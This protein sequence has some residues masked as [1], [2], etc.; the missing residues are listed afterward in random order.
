MHPSRHHPKT[1]I[2][3]ENAEVYYFQNILSP[4]KASAFLKFLLETVPWK[5]DEFIMFGKRIVTKRKFAWY[6]RPDITYT[7]SNSTRYP[8]PWTEELFQLKRIV[9]NTTEREYN[10]CLLN[11]Y[12][13]GEEG[14]GWHRDNEKDLE[15]EGSIASLSLG[16]TR[17]FSFQSIESKE[18]VTIELQSGSLL[19]ME[20]PTQKYW[21]HA[22]L[23]DKKVKDTRIN[24]TFRQMRE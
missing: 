14:M 2:L 3:S 8:L 11:L 22:L 16:A 6:S 23:K 1:R 18:K 7:Y 19:L 10:S 21:K 12:P 20:S 9:E 15:K 5:N 4:E 13:T 17:K 24:L